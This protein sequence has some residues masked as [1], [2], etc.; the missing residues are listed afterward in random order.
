MVPDGFGNDNPTIAVE[1]AP[2]ENLGMAILPIATPAD[3]MRLAVA[4][5]RATEMGMG[6][7]TVE[8]NTK[9]TV[10]FRV[11][12]DQRPNEV[13]SRMASHYGHDVH[14]LETL[15]KDLDVV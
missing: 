7:G 14:S 3:Q 10:S 11:P 1:L 12:K 9:K 2:V 15:L 4:Q 5:R 8:F 13:L 6:G